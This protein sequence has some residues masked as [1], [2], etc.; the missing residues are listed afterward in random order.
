MAR[1]MC[2]ALPP[3]MATDDIATFVKD[4][5]RLVRRSNLNLHK[6]GSIMLAFGTGDVGRVDIFPGIGPAQN[7]IYLL[8][9]QLYLAGVL[10]ERN[11]E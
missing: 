10:T 9:L 2:L 1:R 5:A 8:S 4:R 11:D 3:L 6:V 7:I